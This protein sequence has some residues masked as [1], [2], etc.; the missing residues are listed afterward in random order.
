M[1]IIQKKL[2]EEISMKENLK[3]KITQ[4]ESSIHNLSINLK[5]KANDISIKTHDFEDY[6]KKKNAYIKDLYESG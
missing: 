1:N 2:R 4:Y 5:E 3:K 6:E